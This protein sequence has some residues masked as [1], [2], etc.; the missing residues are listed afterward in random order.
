MNVP[1]LLISFIGLLCFS[2]ALVADPAVEKIPADLVPLQPTL[3][4]QFAFLCLDDATPAS[5]DAIRQS[6][7]RWFSLDS[8][9]SIRAFKR[10]P[11]TD[12]ISWSIG[13]S[14]FVAVLANSAI[15]K[16]DI[17]YASRNSLLHWPDAEKSMLKHKAHYTINC[18]SQ[19]PKPW[20]AALDLTHAIAAF[21]EVHKATGIYW[22]D[23]SIVHAPQTFLVD[24]KHKPGSPLPAALWV[25]MLIESHDTP[26]STSIYTDGMNTLGQLEIEV[27]K[28]EESLQDVYAFMLY[29][30]QEVLDG[31][32]SLET[33]KSLTAPNGTVFSI[34]KAKSAIK[35]KET[36]WL[37]TP[38]PKTTPAK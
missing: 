6:L 7:I 5:D 23:A 19:H 26:K 27:H 18:T 20:M 17:Q 8:P 14:R 1:S 15:P 3:E 9:D 32:I 25:G 12:T 22:G 35:E 2:S 10:N 28:T 30:S 21:T 4:T 13:K 29:L 38:T 33:E 31:N 24:A 34:S 11:D 37:L 16:S 36:I